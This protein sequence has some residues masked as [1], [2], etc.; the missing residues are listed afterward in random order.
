LGTILPWIFTPKHP[1]INSR[2]YRKRWHN[3]NTGGLEFKYNNW[4]HLLLGG[5]IALIL[6]RW[7]KNGYW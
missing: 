4:L 1:L 3:R 5:L 6:I 7:H 2:S